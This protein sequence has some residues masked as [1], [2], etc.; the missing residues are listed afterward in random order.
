MSYEDRCQLLKWPTLSERRK[1]LSLAE[2]YK[3]VFGLY[4]L[5]FEI[6]RIRHN[7]VYEPIQSFVQTLDIKPARLN[8]CKQYFYN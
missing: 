5:K 4:H 8:C 1:Y 6:F 7:K 2:C 3:I